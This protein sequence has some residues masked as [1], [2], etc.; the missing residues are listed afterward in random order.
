MIAGGCCFPA[1][2]S[3]REK[4]IPGRSQAFERARSLSTE[5][6]ELVPLWKVPPTD[7]P[8]YM[9]ACDAMLLTSYHE[10]SPNVV[11]EAMACNLP[12]VAVPV[13]DVAALT[14]G[15]SGYRVR[16]R[17]VEELSAVARRHS[18]G[19]DSVRRSN[20]CSAW[21]SICRALHSESSTF[22]AKRGSQ[23]KDALQH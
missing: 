11:K 2:Q 20:N 5:P 17:N 13:G 14:D 3:S 9:N 4:A 6:L 16:P 7:V 8:L 21:G 10:G 22:I 19:P 18:A 1:T 15:V 23:P 12:V